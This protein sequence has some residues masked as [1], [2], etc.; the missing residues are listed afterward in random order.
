M[1]LGMG[2]WVLILSVCGS[3]AVAQMGAGSGTTKSDAEVTKE[4]RQA[5]ALY[6]H[7]DYLGA[8][9]LFEDLHRDRPTSNQYREQLALCRLA[10][11]GQLPTAEAAAM[12]ESAHSLL[13]EAKA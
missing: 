12:R 5:Q 6:E 3:V 13:L 4:D 8:L 7:Q 10:K 11:A 2:L 9:P 1:R